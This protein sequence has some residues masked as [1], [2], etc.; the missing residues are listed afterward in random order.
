LTRAGWQ[1]VALDVSGI[2]LRHVLDRCEPGTV[3][4]VQ[5]DTDQWPLREEAF[6]LI[7]QVDF[8]ERRLL[9]VLE[10]SLKPGGLLLIDTFLDQGRA[11][12]SGPSRPEFLLKPGELPAVLG[13]LHVCRYDEMRGAT[14]RACFV[15][16]K[17]V[18][19]SAS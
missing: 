12:E 11:N 19:K 17:P 9:S 13:S 16:R 4:A 8:L 3:L 15:G 18:R 1:V 6:D 7:V 2:A 14:A 10:R 5:G